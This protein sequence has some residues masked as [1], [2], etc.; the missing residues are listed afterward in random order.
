MSRLKRI[1]FADA[2][3]LP[4]I[5]A[6][7]AAAVD[8]VLDGGES[9]EGLVRVVLAIDVL[10]HLLRRET[11]VVASHQAHRRIGVQGDAAAFVEI[12]VGHLV[13]SHSQDPTRAT[14]Q[15]LQA[16]LVLDREPTRVSQQTVQMDRP[17]HGRYPVFRK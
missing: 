4:E 6:S 12:D 10:T 9:R 5:P 2:L 17:I 3:D 8:G 14:V 13:I 1:N 15:N 11:A 7:A 16:K